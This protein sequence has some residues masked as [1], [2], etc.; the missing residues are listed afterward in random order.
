M[1]RDCPPSSGRSGTRRAGGR[2]VPVSLQ[3]L[4]EI[5]GRG[6]EADDVSREASL[7]CSTRRG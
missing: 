5:G 2:E 7:F 4:L 3:G 1:G 6:R